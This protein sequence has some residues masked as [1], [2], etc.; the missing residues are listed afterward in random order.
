MPTNQQ[1]PPDINPLP[2]LKDHQFQVSML[3]LSLIDHLSRK[4]FL[5]SFAVHLLNVEKCSVKHQLGKYGPL[6]TFFLHSFNTY[7]CTYWPYAIYC[8]LDFHQMRRKKVKEET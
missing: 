4:H 3:P 8:F 1:S 5:F 7:L 6:A 2:T